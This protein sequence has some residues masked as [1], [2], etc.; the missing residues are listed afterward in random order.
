MDIDEKRDDESAVTTVTKKQRVPIFRISVQWDLTVTTGRH[1][2]RVYEGRTPQ[3]VWQAVMLEGI[4]IKRT[5]VPFD[6]TGVL[7]KSIT[8]QGEDTSKGD[9][10]DE[11]DDEEKQMRLHL[12]RLRTNY[13]R[14]LKTEQNKKL[15]RPL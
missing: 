5:D 11:Q 3:Q 10:L 6:V 7:N 8:L 15:R 14:L 13:L 4:G 1:V 2:V 12:G 9:A